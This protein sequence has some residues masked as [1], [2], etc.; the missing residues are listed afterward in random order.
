MLAVRK[1]VLIGMRQ[2]LTS[3]GVKVSEMPT[4]QLS[5]HDEA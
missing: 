4:A 3:K 2:D 5:G 1:K